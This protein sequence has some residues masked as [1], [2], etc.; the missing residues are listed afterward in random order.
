[1]HKA[2][3]F[4]FFSFFYRSCLCALKIHEEGVVLRIQVRGNVC[5]CDPCRYLDL[6]CTSF[7]RLVRGSLLDVPGP[8]WHSD[9]CVLWKYPCSHHDKVRNVALVAMAPFLCHKIR[10]SVPV[11]N[12]NVCQL[13]AAWTPLLLCSSTVFHI[14][15]AFDNV[16]QSGSSPTMSQRDT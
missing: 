13:N 1:M 14:A 7:W 2:H 3:H 4:F 8:G 15:S 11:L 9:R 6:V 10:K 5:G 12:W 16:S